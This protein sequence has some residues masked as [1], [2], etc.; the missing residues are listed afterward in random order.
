MATWV[1]VCD[2]SR[3]KIFLATRRE[4]DWKLLEDIKHPA[5][6]ET[7]QELH[8]SSPPGRMQVSRSVGARRSSM[9]P[10]T[11]P[12]D[13]EVERFAKHLASRLDAAIGQ[14][15]MDDFVLVAPPHLLG[16][17]RQS[18]AP[19]TV[20]HLKNSV[21]KDLVSFDATETRARLLDV[22]FPLPTVPHKN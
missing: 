14:H 7:S 16:V 11:T 12:K 4:D 9:E 10:H 22:L 18:F 2:A 17:L 13:A 20:K 6:R 21:D 8:P 1:L 15:L 3:A 19:E 5:G